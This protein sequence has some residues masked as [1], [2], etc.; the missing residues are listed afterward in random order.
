MD[1]KGVRGICARNAM[2]AGALPA[3]IRVLWGLWGTH[4]EC[5][6]ELCWHRRGLGTGEVPRSGFMICSLAGE[7]SL[8]FITQIPAQLRPAPKMPTALVESISLV[9]CLVFTAVCHSVR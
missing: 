5:P 9:P 8:L 7:V 1:S 3:F 2:G 6:E 4:R